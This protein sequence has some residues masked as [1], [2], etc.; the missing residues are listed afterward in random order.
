MA[1]YKGYAQRRPLD[2]P[3]L[4]R[5]GVNAI[6]ARGNQ[7][8]AGM[9]RA[10]QARRRQ[11]DE[12]LRTLRSNAQIESR[13][14]DEIFRLDQYFKEQ[15]FN[16]EM[17]NYDR[18]IQ[19]S[20]SSGNSNV[21]QT[22]AKFSQ[23]A[24]GEIS[25]LKE[26]ENEERQ[27][28]GLNLAYKFGLT[29]DDLAILDTREAQL[30]ANSMAV[31]QFRD[32]LVAAGASPEEI[33]M[34]MKLDGRTLYGARVAVLDMAGKYGWDEERNRRMDEEVT[35]GDGR[36]TTLGEQINA[37][38]ISGV[39]E[40]ETRFRID[41]LG[42][43]TGDDPL[44]VGKYLTEPM[45]RRDEERYRGYNAQRS[46]SI[47]SEI[48]ND[49][50]NE[51]RLSA[52]T[53]D[54]PGAALWGRVQEYGVRTGDYKRGRDLVTDVVAEGVLSGEM[55]PEQAQAYLNN[56]VEVAGGTKK[57]RDFYKAD[58]KKILDAISNKRKEDLSLQQLA[59][60]EQDMQFTQEAEEFRKELYSG[61]PVSAEDLEAVME[62]FRSRGNT[63]ALRIAADYIQNDSVDATYIKEKKASLDES[64]RLGIL[65][66]QEVVAARLPMQMQ[67]QY[68]NLAKEAE[69]VG[70]TREDKQDAKRFIAAR[71]NERVK[72]SFSTG[73]TNATRA[74]AERYAVQQFQAD[75]AK[76]RRGGMDDVTAFEK[77]TQ[78]FEAEF[79][80]PGGKYT[81]QGPKDSKGG[82]TI[83]N[84][85]FVNF[86]PGKYVPEAAPFSRIQ[87]SIQ[88]NGIRETLNDPT[89]VPREQ[90]VQY[91][92]RVNNGQT[93]LGGFPSS[94]RFIAEQT[95]GK[96]SLR[97]AYNISAKSQGLP[98]LPETDLENI[99][100]GTGSERFK[101]FINYKPNNVR[102]QITMTEAGFSSRPDQG[103]L[104]PLVS[105]AE[106][107]YESM[108]RGN[109]G[110]SPGSA[111]NYLGKDLRSMTV[112]EVMQRQRRGQ[113]F[114]VGR[115]QIITETMPGFA[116]W[117]A[118]KGLD[119]NSTLYDERTQDLYPRYVEE[120]KRPAV[121]AYLNGQSDDVVE[122]AQELAREFASVPL[123]YPENGNIRGQSRYAGSASNAAHIAPEAIVNALVEEKANRQRTTW[124]QNQNVNPALRSSLP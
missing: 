59:L 85:N 95:G 109:A 2:A 116:N 32:K 76:F 110:D 115:Y 48:V 41:Y 82:T 21:L 62:N 101:R 70:L 69:S 108:N 87:Q 91:A 52:Q 112:S 13:N 34:V 63:Q 97:E 53:S 12:Y 1:A 26:K 104:W 100:K 65:T 37:G 9:N 103:V 56:E 84:A 3:S 27:A 42:Q 71:L 28:F 123:Q 105:S 57:F 18:S 6:Q 38:N 118:S 66:P 14:R 78:K 111:R 89:Y 39:R 77:A 20:R 58:E 61:A 99:V 31:R 7:V 23:Q 44:L 33:E 75:Y 11:A 17:D 93:G 88:S 5:A 114:A 46:K 50:R 122:A 47:R 68:L 81:A 121:G 55:T 22:I 60:R 74:L 4:S 24:F 120:S 40:I 98:E 124:R 86:T 8:I 51:I 67:Q 113:M 72:E 10:E 54:N 94:V 16:A 79:Q 25:K 90:L 15:S 49:E 30:N 35:L 80:K 106:G 73:Q 117:L 83:R 119:P 92:Q 96:L 107:G 102:R 43:F 45:A 36:V 29:R 19:A 64:A